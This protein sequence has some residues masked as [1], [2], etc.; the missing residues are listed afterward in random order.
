MTT[1]RTKRQ[2]FRWLSTR[3]PSSSTRRVVVVTGARQTGKTTLARLT[4]PDLHYVNLDSVEDREALRGVQ[5]ASWA[6]TVGRAV[7][8]EAQKEPSVF[9]K[10]KWA[11]DAKEVDFTALLGSSRILLLNKVRETLAGRA[12]LYDLW[13]LMA[14]ELRH[15]VDEAPAPPLLHRLL[16]ETCS[17]KDSLAEELP[18]LL[19]S[20]EAKRREAVDHLLRWGGM[21]G[22]LPLDDH[23]RKDW[24]RSYQQTFLERDLT[25]LVRLGDL[26]PFRSLQRLCMLRSGQL[27]SYSELARD[28]GLAVTT[29]RR[30]LEYLRISYQIILL[31]PYGR[32]LTSRQVKAP[33]LF[34]IDLGLLREGTKQ[35]GDPTGAM[36]ET[37]VIGE[38][39]KFVNTVA[40]DADLYFYR[41]RSGM[42]VDLLIETPRGVLAMEIKNRTTVAPSDARS[43]RPLRR[44]LGS[45]WLG[46]LVVYRGAEIAPVSGDDMIWAVPVH[47]LL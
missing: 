29:V 12:F 31:R 3:L 47:R 28:A 24:L 10:I 15:E 35:W 45:S 33:K 43:L 30:Y 36:F 39:H 17:L 25:D 23:D 44:Q 8:D 37:L 9:E 11:F 5:T 40:L 16:T 1:M 7:L 21:P 26:H 41:T 38:I 32:N 20:D 27:L 18:L 22:L 34:W 46:G 19:G 4:Y 6:R 14:S 13:P 42:E 2:L